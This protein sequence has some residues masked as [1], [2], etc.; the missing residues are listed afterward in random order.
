MSPLYP[1]SFLGGEGLVLLLLLYSPGAATSLWFCPLGQLPAVSA[2]NVGDILDYVC[3]LH[4]Y[5]SLLF[6]VRYLL[7]QHWFGTGRS[8][9]LYLYDGKL[10]G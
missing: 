6:S 3:S 10:T 1:K 4:L 2:P 7:Q 8:F 5:C 9:H